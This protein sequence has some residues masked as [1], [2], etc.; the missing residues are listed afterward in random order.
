MRSVTSL[1]LVL[2]LLASGCSTDS[3]SSS[4]SAKA[5]SQDGGGENAAVA[6]DW[7]VFGADIGDGDAVAVVDLLANPADFQGKTLRVEGAVEQVCKV[8]GC[9]MTLTS[10][11][12]SMRVQFKDYGFFVPLDCEGR[13]V[14]IE[15]EFAV[16]EIPE[17]EA[18]HY[19]EDAGDHEGA[20]KI[21]GPQKQ[22]TFMAEGVRM[23]KAG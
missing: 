16:K 14:V 21:V 12:E 20:A 5:A 9:W 19:L 8:K 11:D 3:D 23:K 6:G 17:D 18:K 1:A 2:S 4:S 13:D 22:F 15:G 10:G 7:E